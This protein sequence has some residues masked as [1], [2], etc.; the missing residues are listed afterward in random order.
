MTDHP[1]FI[2]VGGNPDEAHLKYHGGALVEWVLRIVD[3]VIVGRHRNNALCTAGRPKP[4]PARKAKSRAVVVA[5]SALAIFG[6][7][8]MLPRLL[9]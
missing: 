4:T 7:A 9:T 5:V 2:P 3:A 8:I 6:A 1:R